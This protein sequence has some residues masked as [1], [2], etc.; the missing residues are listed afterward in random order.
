M[1]GI[2]I[3][4]PLSVSKYCYN[5]K[6]SYHYHHLHLFFST[7]NKTVLLHFRSEVTVK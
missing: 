7:V 4:T 1:F 6:H 3:N 5:M 2:Y